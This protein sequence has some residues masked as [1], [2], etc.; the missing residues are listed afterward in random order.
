MAN[1]LEKKLKSYIDNILLPKRG[2]LLFLQSD[3]GNPN[4]INMIGIS[5]HEDRRITIVPKRGSIYVSLDNTKPQNPITEPVEYTTTTS[6]NNNKNV[7]VWVE[8]AN[9][10][11]IF[12]VENYYDL[13]NVSNEASISVEN[14]QYLNNPKSINISYGKVSEMADFSNLGNIIAA[15]FTKYLT[16]DVSYVN[17][18]SKFTSIV[19]LNMADGQLPITLEE[20]GGSLSTTIMNIMLTI[21]LTTGTIEG[22]VAKQVAKGRTAQSTNMEITAY[23][24]AP[25]ITFKGSACAA[26]SKVSWA[27]SG[28]NTVVTCNSVS[29][30]IHVNSDGTWTRVS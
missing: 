9:N 11:G 29:T 16:E 7:R 4:G 26:K 10:D 30:T 18:L 28:E 8:D 5:A 2:E 6:S 25:Q 1:C 13:G 12:S 19:D 14:L 20:L 24:Y 27:A 23:N 15:T 3:M 22:F 21:T 17:V